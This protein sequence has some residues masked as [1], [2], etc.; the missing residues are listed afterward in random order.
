ML[1]DL[2][3]CGVL[4]G[5]CIC[6][7]LGSKDSSVIVLGAIQS[8]YTMLLLMKKYIACVSLCLVIHTYQIQPNDL[9]S[10]LVH[11]DVIRGDMWDACASEEWPR[12]S[13]LCASKL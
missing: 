13:G 8:K 1:S 12:D 6:S 5:Q 7:V 10:Q 9:L 2:C 3:N 11:C 4:S